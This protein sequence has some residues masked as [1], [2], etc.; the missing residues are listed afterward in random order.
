MTIGGVS[1]CFWEKSLRNWNVN[2]LGEGE[3]RGFIFKNFNLF[4]IRQR[5]MRESANL[6]GVFRKPSDFGQ[7]DRQNGIIPLI[8]QNFKHFTDELR[9]IFRRQDV[10]TMAIF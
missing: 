10:A 4:K 9:G 3:C 8:F 6:V 2:L 5:Q 1:F 7:T